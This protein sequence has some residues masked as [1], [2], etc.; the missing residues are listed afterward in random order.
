MLQ[1]LEAKKS[2]GAK[3]ANRFVRRNLVSF[4]ARIAAWWPRKKRNCVVRKKSRTD[5]KPGR[6]RPRPTRHSSNILRRRMDPIATILAREFSVRLL[7]SHNSTRLGIPFQAPPQLH[8][9]VRQDATGRR[10]VS[11]LDIGNGP[12]SLAPCFQ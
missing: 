12:R 8:R 6:P 4:A 5:R 3:K 1:S 9:N 7:I 10:N 2:W 11:L